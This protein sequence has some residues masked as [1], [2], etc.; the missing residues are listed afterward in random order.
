MEKAYTTYLKKINEDPRIKEIEEKAVE[1]ISSLRKR[2]EE[3][4]D[5]EDT[6]FILDYSLGEGPNAFAAPM[7]IPLP[8]IENN[9]TRLLNTKGGKKHL[10]A[11]FSLMNEKPSLG[12]VER[13]EEH[14]L[15]TFA[16]ESPDQFKPRPR[17]YAS[18]LELMLFPDLFTTVADFVK[19]KEKARLLGFE[20]LGK[21]FEEVQYLVRSSID[22]YL[23]ENNLK[24]TLT[25]FQAAA[26][27][28]E[29]E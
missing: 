19:I 29:I 10:R 3:L 1:T 12:L 8:N 23:E 27:A 28:W 2:I 22:D 17:L 11:L 18:R 5:F 26:L 15:N 20:T 7:A 14:S 6:S 13:I 9:L 4:P 21:S 24:D 25:S 16:D